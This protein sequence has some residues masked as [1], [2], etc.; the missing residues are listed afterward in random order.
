MNGSALNGPTV[1]GPTFF[2]S[3]AIGSLNL[4]SLANGEHRLTINVV[5][6]I[7]HGNAGQ[8]FQQ[9]MM[10]N[11]TVYYSASYVDTVNFCIDATASPNISILSPQNQTYM[12]GDIPL[13]FTLNE[14]ATNIS[15]SLDGNN[16]IA[17]NGNTT[18]TGLSIGEHNLT[19]QAQD[20]A[21]NIGTSQTA[22][23]FITNPTPTSSPLAK[24]SQTTYIA[25]AIVIL[26]A[27]SSLALVVY[28]KKRRN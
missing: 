4:P 27:A 10:P 2:L 11:G 6:N 14:Q 15:Y 16:S 28:L 25:P 20:A 26:A 17:I 13:S 22:D 7:Y 5:A 23:F 3:E 8:P 12:A 24:P 21:G 18:L 19:I 9:K 1:N